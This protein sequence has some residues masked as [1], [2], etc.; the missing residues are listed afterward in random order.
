VTEKVSVALCTHNG[1][2]FVEEQLLSILRQSPPPDEIVLSDDASTDNTVALAIAL[3]ESH[4][5]PRP[6]LI[7]LRNRQALGVTANFEKAI[8][9]TGFNLIALCDQDDIWHPNRLQRVTREFEYRPDLDLLFTDAR[10]V[11]E[12]GEDLGATLFDTLE[13]TAHDVAAVHRG[14]GISIFI[15]RNIATGATIMFR[16]RLLDTALPFPDSWVHD[17]W[18]AAI[19]ATVGRLDVLEEP[20]IDYRQHSSN[21]I[22]VVV[23]SLRRKIRR[24]FEG[25]GIRN[26]RLAAQYSQL[27]DRLD[28]ALVTA[29]PEVIDGVRGKASFETARES[30]PSARFGRIPGVAALSRRGG[31]RRYAS[32]GRLDILRDLL[33]GH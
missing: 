26:A 16:R 19:A 1:A 23:P 10:L 6:K 25:R 14:E 4:A 20:T 31:Y 30:L 22:G 29:P 13:V 28:H 17:E 8:R 5:L 12:A 15:K 9:A 18:L 33:Q 24:V 32:Q 21:Q 27:A 2:R 11:G 7:V 3:V